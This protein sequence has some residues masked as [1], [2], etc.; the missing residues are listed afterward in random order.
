MRMYHTVSNDALNGEDRPKLTELMALCTQLSSMVLALETTKSAQAKE[1]A[2]LKKRV[3]K[4]ERRKKSG[5]S[6]LKRL[7]K[8]GSTT[9]IESSGDEETV[10]GDQEDASKQ[11]RS[12]ADIDED[13]RVILDNTTFIDADLFGVHDL[14]GEEVFVDKEESKTVDEEMTLAQTLM[15]IKTKAKGIDKGKGKMVEEPE[16]PKSKKA[17]IMLNEQL[18]LK[19]QAEEEEAAKNIAE[20]DDIQARIDA[21]Y[22]LAEQLQTQEHGELTVKEKSKLFVELMDKRKKQFARLR[23]EE[24]RRK[25]LTKA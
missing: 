16:K 6:K 25:P 2:T 21:D 8:V 17:Q 14:E 15:D 1:I 18:A 4:L 22:E 13:A 9:R 23:A 24:Q 20:W 12:I 5:S 7:F 10:L 11:G 19:L 3:N